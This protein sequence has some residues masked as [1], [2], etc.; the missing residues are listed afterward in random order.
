[1]RPE[2]YQLLQ[3]HLQLVSLE[4]SQVLVEP[5][6]PVEDVYFL[7]Y[8]IASAVATSPGA[9]RIEIGNIGREGMTG[10]CVVQGVDRTPLLVFMQV[11]GPASRLAVSVLKDAMAASPTLHGLLLRYVESTIIQMAH[12]A[13]A[14][15]RHNLG[16]RLA[17]WLLMS[18]DRL[19]RDEIPLTHEFLSLMLG[20]RR[21][22]V[23]EALHV[24]EGE[25]IIKAVRGS[26]TILDRAKLE[27]AARDSYGVPEAEY[28]RLIGNSMSKFR[29]PERSEI[30]SRP[31]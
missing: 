14:N 11:A 4:V 10:T 3:P 22:G 30:E 21:P 9:E 1:M 7:E 23:T 19:E 12:S 13:L 16:Q 24:L 8:G 31:S 25:H 26:I 17:R 27:D 5:N 18:Q 20:V 2:D 6:R 29:P 15:G 28:E